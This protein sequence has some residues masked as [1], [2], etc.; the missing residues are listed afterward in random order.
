MRTTLR[1]TSAVM[2]VLFLS[3]AAHA[4][5]GAAEIAGVVKDPS[6]APIAGAKVPLTNQDSGVAR[7]FSSDSDGRYRFSAIAPGRYSLKSEATGFR[8][9]TIT[10]IVLNTGTHLDKDVPLTVGSLQEVITVTA[11]V[12]PVD[13]SKGEVSGVVT[14]VQI[15]SLPVNT[16]QYL[17]LALLMPG[18][19]ED[20]SRTFYNK[21]EI[22]GGGRFYANGFTVDGVTNTW[23]EQGEP[24][25]NFPQGAV[26][27][28][29]VNTNQF[30]A[31]QGLAMGGVVNIVTKSGTHQFHGEAFEYFRNAVLNHDNKFTEAALQ[32]VGQTGKEPFNRNQF[33][34]DAGGPICNNPPP[35]YPPHP[36]PNPDHSSPIF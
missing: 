4:Q 16:R 33:G 5:V 36:T 26:Q 25:Q 19:T 31:E 12:P 27:E 3:A 7:T 34:G 8:T 22:G 30:N 35:F 2:V 28:F 20:A 29:R 1:W 13:T 24:R 14:Q 32:Q 11:E 21:V 23:A 6:G 9:E 17:N 18:T 15:D 10:D